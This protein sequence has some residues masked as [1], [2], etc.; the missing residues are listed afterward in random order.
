ML[1]AAIF[2]V[3]FAGISPFL[4]LGA[5]ANDARRMG[6]E[7]I[8]ADTDYRVTI[9]LPRRASPSQVDTNAHEPP[10]MKLVHEWNGHS[11]DVWLTADGK[12]IRQTFEFDPELNDTV[13]VQKYGP[14]NVPDRSTWGPGHLYFS[15][16]ASSR[17]LVSFYLRAQLKLSANWEQP[18]GAGDLKLFQMFPSHGHGYNVGT[19]LLGRK[20]ALRFTAYENNRSDPR[21]N[22]IPLGQNPRGSAYVR[23]PPDVFTLNTWHT[24]EV[25]VVGSSPGA[26]DGRIVTWLDGKKQT[27]LDNMMWVSAGE[28]GNFSQFD[29]NS[30][31]GGQG[32]SIVEP[33][34][35]Y[36]G[37]IYLSGSSDQLRISAR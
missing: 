34:Y 22:G 24:I 1:F 9:S 29:L 20:D 14:W 36:V 12:P 37:K 30:L 23:P 3:L 28:N 18:P 8:R 32:G 33:Q 10:N 4:Q 13:M 21:Y 27:D 6:G 5:S 26:Q 2:T 16:P 11:Q 19:I 7:L 15:I 31:W 17:P 35:M 25:L